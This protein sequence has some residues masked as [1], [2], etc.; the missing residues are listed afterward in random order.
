MMRRVSQDIV[1][2]RGGGCITAPGTPLSKTAAG[3]AGGATRVTPFTIGLVLVST[4]MHASWNLLVPNQKARMTFFGRMVVVTVVV[5]F[6]PAMASEASAR[7]LTPTAWACAAGSGLFCGLYYFFLAHAYK[8][9]DFTI[10]YPIARA[11]PV[12]M[13][14]VGDVL[15]ARPITPLSWVGMSIV[16][17]GCFLSPLHSFREVSLGRYINRATLWMVLAA[18]GTVGYTMLDK[19]AAEV[20]RSGPATAARYGYVFFLFSWLG[21]QGLVRTARIREE[22]S[23]AVGWRIPVVASALN[24]GAYWLILW[25]YQMSR[26]ASYITTYRQFGIVVGVIAAFVIYR[27]RGLFVRLTGAVMITAG[28]IIVGLWGG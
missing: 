12:L 22:E 5:G 15:R 3:G 17:L 18:L 24:F 21:Y 23:A 13:V 9:S 26:H 25:A 1:Y 27:E 10:V 11:L 8:S 19:Y 7:S 16:V 14:A 4:L 28:L 20:V 6:V 2:T